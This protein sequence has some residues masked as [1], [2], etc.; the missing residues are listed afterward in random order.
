[1]VHF[2]YFFSGLTNE[3]MLANAMLFFLAGKDTTSNSLGYFMHNMAVNPECQATLT[4]EIDRVVG[5]KV[6]G[7]KCLLTQTTLNIF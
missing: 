5:D 3:E 6:K 7:I 4:T 1:M 2:R